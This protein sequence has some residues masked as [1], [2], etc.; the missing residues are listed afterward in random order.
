MQNRKILRTFWILTVL[1]LCVSICPGPASASEDV[2]TF[3]IFA[4]RFDTED[5]VQ[6]Y[7]AF[8]VRD[9]D[10]GDV[11][12][13]STAEA[14]RQAQTGCDVFL[15]GIGYTEPAAYVETVGQVA[16][17][18]APGLDQVPPYK[19]GAEIPE[20]V[21]FCF[22]SETDGELC[23][24]ISDTIVLEDGWKD[25][26]GYLLAEGNTVEDTSI[27]GAAV[28]TADA[29]Q[30][31]GM[32]TRNGDNTLAILPLVNS[33][34]PSDAAAVTA[35][36]DLI[37]A[38]E[39]ED[40]AG[41]EEPEEGLSP[42]MLVYIG[43]GTV[44]LIGILVAANKKP[45][46]KKSDGA[47]PAPVPA[48][49]PAD[50][51]TIAL[52]RNEMASE[53]VDFTKPSPAVSYSQN[54]KASAQWQLRCI[55]GPLEGQTFPLHDKLSIGRIPDNDVVFSAETKGVSGRHCE[56]V[57]SNGRVILQDLNATYG[58]YFGMEQKAK[59]KPNMDYQ[60][61]HG[62]VFI[63]AEGGPAFRLESLTGAAVKPGFTVRGAS[64]TLYRA[65]A[66]GEITFG[67]NPECV[68]AF[69]QNNTA[70]SARHCKLF[71]KE[72]TLYL[73]DQGS[74]NGT[75]FSE[76]QRLKPNV[77]Y[78]VTKGARFCLVNPQN[79]FVIT[80]D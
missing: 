45:S 33:V 65:N 36:G 53:L 42:Q 39:P 69:D 23:S 9:S 15:C 19:L 47:A 35:A 24:M 74:T 40:D 50:S 41:Q 14:A 4:L 56:V 64:G 8:C 27:L 38:A 30:V 49:Q 13:I 48:P 12:L 11:Y 7:S 17:F 44:L 61:Q 68:V 70:V 55:R 76:D 22:V 59:L 3:P 62:D 21:L 71:R 25:F 51:G 58:T 43:I 1:L 79:T 66:D 67:R 72:D 73:V 5:G 2:E 34:F 46:A 16:Y 31:V 57:L 60:L 26:G 75:F 29:T 20:T 54:G 6:E 77:S 78:K 37:S 28:L 52:K 80:E 32:V 10:S 63:L 18:R